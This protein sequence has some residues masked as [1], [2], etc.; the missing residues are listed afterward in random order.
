MKLEDESERSPDAVYEPGSVYVGTLQ[1]TFLSPSDMVL[2][3]V[4]GICIHLVYIGILIPIIVLFYNNYDGL[5]SCMNIH[6]DL[7]LYLLLLCHLSILCTNIAAAC[8]SLG[9]KSGGTNKCLNRLLLLRLILNIAEICLVFYGFYAVLIDKTNS[10]CWNNNVDADNDDTMYILIMFFLVFNLF[11]LVVTWCCIYCCLSSSSP[12]EQESKEDNN[13]L[14]KIFSACIYDEKAAKVTTSFYGMGGLINIL[15]QG[16]KFTPA[17]IITG[18]HLL[19]MLQKHYGILDYKQYKENNKYYQPI[20]DKELLQECEYYTLY[21]NA[22]YGIPLYSM[23]NPC[24]I[25]CAPPCCLPNKFDDPYCQVFDDEIECDKLV[26][27]QK[28]CCNSIQID[29]SS[30]KIFIQRTKCQHPQNDVLMVSQFGGLHKVNFYVIADHHRKAIIIAI[31]GTLSLGDAI[32][33]ANTEPELWDSKDKYFANCDEKCYVHKGIGQCAKD[34]FD[35][36]ISSKAIIK[37]VKNEL[38][39]DYDFVITGH[40]LGGGSTVLL[41]MIFRYGKHENLKYFIND[42]RKF[43]AYAIA[44]P[45]CID[46]EFALKKKEEMSEFLTCVIYGHDMIPRLSFNGL[47]S[48]RAAINI[49][50]TQLNQAK[51]PKT[52]WWVYRKAVVMKHDTICK[53]LPQNCIYCP[54]VETT[55]I[56]IKEDD[57]TKL[58]LPNKSSGE[59]CFIKDIDQDVEEMR[60][61]YNKKMENDFNENKGDKEE[62]EKYEESDKYKNNQLLWNIKFCQ[63]GKGCFYCK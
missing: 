45:S 28:K 19:R 29:N 61:I 53:A 32:T 37:F 57:D 56:E 41:S 51:K 44:P 6:F 23:S 50:L 49:L 42:N 34:A 55:T 17:E 39:K 22:A 13:C 18:L 1:T 54:D 21:S 8:S 33:D 27:R 2:P 25:C 31:R 5:E 16:T 4:C 47:V 11:I 20:N 9:A 46:R 15:S 48:T 59:S 30:F 14:H 36:I 58:L 10:Q 26:L 52:P 43:K 38:F 7:E 40:S 62:E 12:I 3:L 35:K 60:R 24:A 63:A